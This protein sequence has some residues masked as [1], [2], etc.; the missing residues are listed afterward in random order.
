[1]ARRPA[2]IGLT[3]EEKVDAFREHMDEIYPDGLHKEIWNHGID[4]PNGTLYEWWWQF[5]KANAEIDG[6]TAIR[7]VGPRATQTLKAFGEL[8]SSFIEWWECGGA[9]A[10]REQQ[11]PKIEVRT[12]QHQENANS[13][14]D[15]ISI[16][17]PLGISRKLI[18][19]QIDVLLDHFHEN[20]ELKRHK[21]S[22]AKLKIHP[23]PRYRS[24]NYREF[25]DVWMLRQQ[26]LAANIERPFWEIYC[27]VSGLAHKIPALGMLQRNT[28]D[29]RKEYG[30]RGHELFTIAETMMRNALRGYFP[31][32]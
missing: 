20:A 21:A 18:H 5:M 3:P 9:E 14:F 30:K 29:E 32:N 23:K 27:L 8:R 2:P 7:A 13:E 6:N 15:E 12:Y 24:V 4:G 26:D 25:L 1:M 31:K 11:V 10:F 28:E 19:A 17:L 22:T 16:V